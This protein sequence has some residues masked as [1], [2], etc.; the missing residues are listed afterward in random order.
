[1]KELKGFFRG[2]VVNRFD[3]SL[4]FIFRFGLETGSG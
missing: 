3:S 4:G 1:M 2:Y